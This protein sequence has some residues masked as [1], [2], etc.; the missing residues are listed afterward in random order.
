MKALSSLFKEPSDFCNCVCVCVCVCLGQ[1][2]QGNH[3][4]GNQR[5]NSFPDLVE[6]DSCHK[7]FIRHLLACQMVLS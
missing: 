3:A 6:N 2:V 4:K 5:D 1:N 7:P